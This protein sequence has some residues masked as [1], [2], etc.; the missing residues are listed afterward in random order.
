MDKVNWVGIVDIWAFK[1]TAFLHDPPDKA[2][3]ISNHEERRNEILRE[4]G[5]PYDKKFDK[6]DHISAAMQ[7]LNVPDECG[8][9]RLTVD[10]YHRDMPV[11][12]HTLSADEEPLRELRECKDTYGHDKCFEKYKFDSRKYL[13][14]LV[15]GQ[16]WKASYFKAWRLLPE[17]YSLGS[18]LPADTR[19][20]NDCIW[21]HLD[22]TSAVLGAMLPDFREEEVALMSVK[23]PAVQDFIFHSRKLSDLW[24]GSHLAAYLMFE[25]LMAIVEEQGPDAIIFPYLRG[26]PFLDFWL[27]KNFT[28]PSKEL[29]VEEKKLRVANIP[30][31]FLAIIPYSKA[32]R[33]KEDIKQRI[34]MALKQASESAKRLLQEKDISFDEELW[35]RQIENVLSVH[36]VYAKLLNQPRYEQAKNQNLIPLYLKERIDIWLEGSAGGRYPINVGHFYWPTYELLQPILTQHSRLFKQY[37]EGPGRKCSMCGIRNTII[38][39]EEIKKLR[40]EFPKEFREEEYLCGICLTKRF[41]RHFAEEKLRLKMPVL[42]FPSVAT[43]ATCIWRRHLR[44]EAEDTISFFG[45]IKEVG[46]FLKKEFFDPSDPLGTIDGEFLYR[47]TFTVEN[48]EDFYGE[49]VKK[50]LEIPRLLSEAQKILG[51][52]YGKEKNGKKYGSPPKYYAI[53]LMDGDRMGKMLSGEAL[54]EFDRFLHP[55]FKRCVEEVGSE[56]LKK[57]LRGKRVLSP[58]VHMAISRALKDF[59]II[60]VGDIVEKY[61][62]FMV[63]SG[64]DDILALFPADRVMEVAKELKEAY[65]RDFYLHEAGGKKQKLMGLGKEAS[66]SA[67]IVFVHYKYPLYDALEQAREAEKEAKDK[68]KRNAFALRFIKRSGETVVAGG[69]WDFVAPLLAV[70]K[71][72]VKGEISHKFIYDLADVSRVLDGDKLLAETRRLL[73]RR[74]EDKAVAEETY[75]RISYLLGKFKSHD[76]PVQELPQA[77]KILYDAFR[78]EE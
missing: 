11:F 9:E 78:G 23:L 44:A 56:E 73:R 25:G 21:D 76:F 41:Y 50:I 7:R 74:S 26:Q 32:K 14:G 69:K 39:K 40:E 57:T 43:I 47:E 16:D 17:R 34:Q 42:R 71:K 58:S 55:A 64:G 4:I 30:N 75:A 38:K 59:S 6:A 18:L 53:L 70:A 12:K 63:Y 61:D 13:D 66:M 68:Y 35:N 28:W 8:A 51:K 49:A 1:L 31:V 72:L 36:A 15:D 24:A 33:L 5:L 22:A 3:K 54:P 52:I 29:K 65:S 45:I 62:G 60:V 2:L 77:L 10:L 46:K 48:F 67:G 19:M 20:P 27:S 37:V